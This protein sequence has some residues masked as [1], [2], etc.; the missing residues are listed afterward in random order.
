M[1]EIGLMYHQDSIKP[2]PLRQFAVT[3][4]EEAFHA[5]AKENRTGKVVITYQEEDALIKVGSYRTTLNIKL[6]ICAVPKIT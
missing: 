5:F 6:T 3:N 1:T 2:I 4:I